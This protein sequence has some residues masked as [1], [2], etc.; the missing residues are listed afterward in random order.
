VFRSVSDGATL[1]D[2]VLPAEAVRLPVEL[3]GVDRVL[4]HS[5]LLE[6]FRS[7]FCPDRG[8]RS[9]P[10]EVYLRLMYLK[11]SNR[12]GYDRLME[13]VSGSITYKVFAR[14]PI[15]ASVPDPSTLKHLTKRFRPETIA[16]LNR[17]LVG[18]AVKAGATD[19]SRVRVDTTTV[20]A[21]IAYPTDSGLLTKAVKQLTTAATTLTT[22]LGLGVRVD[23][24]SGEVAELNRQLGAWARTRHPDRGAE[25]LGITD[26]LADVAKEVGETAGQVLD[27]ASAALAGPDPV[28]RHARRALGRLRQAQEALPALVAQ[29]KARALHEAVPAADKRL[30]IRDRDA[31]P[32]K[33]ATTPRKQIQFGY[34]AQIAEDA[35]GLIVDYE[36]F[37]GQPADAELIPP[38]IKRI[39]GQCG[40]PALVTADKTYGTTASRQALTDL[41]VTTVAIA[42][43]SNQKPPPPPTAEAARHLN[44]AIKWRAGVEAR[45]ATLKRDHGWD[46]TRMA[47]LTG[48]QTWLGFGVFAHN[49]RKLAR[50]T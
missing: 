32:I 21:G 28:P 16:D 35:A 22:K 31:R 30:S 19:V 39:A 15:D 5:G 11:W 34:T 23:D 24:L 48:A 25:I 46:R 2:S 14:I 7:E 17:V 9:I 20:D 36:V 4:D 41:G 1:W 47:N 3:A 45:I 50:L 43:K 29:A 33:K 27:A 10:M 8:R 38:A 49:T 12:W 18:L 26:Q 6:V 40:T 44:T 42:Y 13:I 37:I